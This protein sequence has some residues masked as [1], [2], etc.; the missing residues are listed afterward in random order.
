[1]ELFFISLGKIGRVAPA[2]DIITMQSEEAVKTCKHSRF[3]F[4][5]LDFN[6]PIIESFLST[7]VGVDEQKDGNNLSNVRIAIESELILARINMSTY[8]VYSKDSCNNYL[9]T[10]LLYACLSILDEL[11]N[12]ILR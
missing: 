5:C 1:M 6:E 10:K 3:S 7:T 4:S 11:N 2:I 9:R 8:S 12:I